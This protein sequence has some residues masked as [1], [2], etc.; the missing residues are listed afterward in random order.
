MTI[1]GVR[2]YD[3]QGKLKKELSQEQALDHFRSQPEGTYWANK[4]KEPRKKWCS[5]INCKYCGERIKV[6]NPK[7]VKCKKSPCKVK[8]QKWKAEEKLKEEQ[9]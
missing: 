4:H 9:R 6:F 7:A 1:Y 5:Y 3:G 2:I 8:H